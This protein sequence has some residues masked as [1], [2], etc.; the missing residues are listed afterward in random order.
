MFWK[1]LF[2]HLLYISIIYGKICNHILLDTIDDV[3]VFY[4]SS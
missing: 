1:S 3:H 4:N 2:I